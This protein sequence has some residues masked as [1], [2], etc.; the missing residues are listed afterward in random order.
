MNHPTALEKCI[1]DYMKE[2]I[3]LNFSGENF[4]VLYHIDDDLFKLYINFPNGNVVIELN[5]D[6]SDMMYIYAKI[7]NTKVLAM[8][9]L[10]SNQ[11]IFTKAIPCNFQTLADDGWVNVIFAARGAIEKKM[12]EAGIK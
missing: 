2:I 12:K 1:I 11:E 9:E 8:L 10:A 7:T 3:E 6:E 4:D 5:N